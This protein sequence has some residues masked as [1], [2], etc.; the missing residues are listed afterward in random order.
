MT[1]LRLT[2]SWVAVCLLAFASYSHAEVLELEGV[3]KAVDAADRTL[4]VERKTPKGTK[5]LEL[6]V[7][8]R[9]GDLSSVKVGDR[10]TFS[11]DPD[12]ELV[13]KLGGGTEKSEKSS[14]TDRIVRV[15]YHVSADGSCKL[16][17]VKLKAKADP[18]AGGYKK[19]DKGSGIWQITETFD[20]E[21][22]VARFS[23]PISELTNVS[24]SAE[25][26]ALTLSPKAGGKPTAVLLYPKR[27]RLPLTIEVDIS[28]AEEHGH[29]Q[30]NP[31]A[32]MPPN[33]H[34]FANVFT[35]DGGSKLDLSCNWV[36]SRD[37]KTGEPTIEEVFSERGVS[38]NEPFSKEARSPVGIDPE[39]IYLVRLGAFG[40]GPDSSTVYISRLSMAARFAP[41]LGLALKQ[42]GDRVLADNVLKKSLA[43]RAGIKAGDVVV[44]IDGKSPSTVQRA[45]TLLS[46]TNYG[47]SWN[48]EVERDGRRKTLTIK[49]E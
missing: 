28:T 39:M 48:I 45:V 5:T 44:S 43:E 4:S 20:D 47:E 11:Y 3:V 30:I 24:Y 34:P 46:M 41:T 10:I 22:S 31:N 42:D 16:E 15:R 25:R 33:I 37:P 17:T 12:L 21:D 9:A 23:G 35:H 40:A 38:T 29:F 8:K 13:T 32:A 27:C 6:E 18:V 14:D 36:V 1:M 2:G 49:A 26:K 7:N 19:E